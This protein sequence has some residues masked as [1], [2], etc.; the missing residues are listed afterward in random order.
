MSSKEIIESEK[1]NRDYIILYKEGIFWKAYQHSA[2]ALSTQVKPLK[3]QRRALACLDGGDIVYVG[4][5]QS[6]AD[7]FLEGVQGC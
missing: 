5:P 6:S 7:K 2:F 4:F 1:N 3:A